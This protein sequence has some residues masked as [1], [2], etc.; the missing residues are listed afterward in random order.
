AFPCYAVVF[1]PI[2]SA[3]RTATGEK[4]RLSPRL[5]KR[6]EHDVRVMRIENDVDAACVFIFGQN[7]R[8]GFAAVG[9]A[10][11]SALLVPAKCMTQ[12]RYQS[13]ILIS[14]I[15]N[16]RADLSRIFQPDVLPCFTAVDRFKDSSAVG[17]IASNRCFARADIN[18]VVIRWRY[19][20]R[21]NR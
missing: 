6:C 7:F 15:D 18:Y 2:Q 13:H 20:D 14:W 16:Q 5:P 1:R 9:C 11:N 4:P 3:A 21:A 17:G 10:K 8:P 19:C 12:R